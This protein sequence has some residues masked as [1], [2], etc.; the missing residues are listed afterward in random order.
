M[1]W[2]EGFF[3]SACAFCAAHLVVNDHPMMAVG[4][5]AGMV[6]WVALLRSP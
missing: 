3:S 1:R 6:V 4:L 2:P 5:V